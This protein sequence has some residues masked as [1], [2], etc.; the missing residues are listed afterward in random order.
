MNDKSRNSGDAPKRGK[1]KPYAKPV[2]HTY[3]A[4]RVI[5]ENIGSMT[6]AD[7]GTPPKTKT[8]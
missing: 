7:A 1:R 8:A 2:L 3:G 4:I 5:T 6:L